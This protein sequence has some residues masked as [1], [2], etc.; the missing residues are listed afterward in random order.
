MLEIQNNQIV[1]IE[2]WTPE[3]LQEKIDITSRKIKYLTEQISQTQIELDN[4][5]SFQNSPQLNQIIKLK[6]LE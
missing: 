6:K 4:L 2:N 1:N 5:T 3:Q